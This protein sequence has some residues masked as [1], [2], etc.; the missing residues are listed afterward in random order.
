M[1]KNQKIKI[2]I[3]KKRF[4]S[5]ISF[6]LA[7]VFICFLCVT[8]SSY[9]PYAQKLKSLIRSTSR[10]MVVLGNV[11][12]EP[13]EDAY[14]SVLYTDGT[15]SRNEKANPLKDNKLIERKEGITRLTDFCTG[16]SINL[17]EDLEPDFSHSPNFVKLTSDFLDV[18]ISKE[19][20]PYEDMDEYI[21][22]YLNRFI[23]NEEYRK[24][25]SMELLIDDTLAC[26]ENKARII[27]VNITDMPKDKKNIYTFATINTGEREFFRFMFKFRC[28]NTDETEKLVGDAL[29]SFARREG[30]GTPA[31]N[32]YFEPSEPRHWS[33]DTKKVYEKM[34]N[35]DDILWGIF[36]AQVQEAG[37]N[38]TIPKIEDSI[39]FKFPIVLI[40][41]HLGRPL[42][43]GFAAKCA[44]QGRMIELTLQMTETNNENLHAKSPLLETYKGNYDDK[45]RALAREIKEEIKLPFF[46]RLNNEMNT[47]WTSYSGIINLSD[48]EIYVEAWRRVYEIFKDEGVDNA[49]WVFNPNDRNYPPCNWNNFMAYYPGDEYVQMIGVTGY[50]TGT[51]FK[52]VTGEDWRSFTEI[53]DEVDSAYGPFFREFPW[54]ITEFA[55]SSVGGN[56]PMW[57]SHMF[58]NLH[59]YPNIKAAVWF[60]APDMDMREGYEGKI[61]R[62]YMLD[63]TPESL[64]A[65]ARGIK[66]TNPP[67]AGE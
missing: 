11:D 59:K 44:E 9:K 39:N 38:E 66:K 54:I 23:T 58:D 41:N 57:I 32:L 6:I 49:I 19:R 52:D 40:Y 24:N 33:N 17:P 1:K 25:N 61:S 55:S 3:N 15:P 12:Y 64:D 27:S 16:F 22:Y 53:Y 50:N 34:K 37:I 46:F 56:K 42:S 36:T 30:V 43:D 63:E 29:A 48:P 18:T 35:R 10:Q 31:Y 20:S 8:Y 26:G 67:Q 21:A 51:Y 14:D 7:A 62:P 2:K 65:F 60:S 45:I 47:D 13:L 5:F 4:F 28:E